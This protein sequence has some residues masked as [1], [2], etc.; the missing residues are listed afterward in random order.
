MLAGT[1]LTSNAQYQVQNGDF[2]T[3]T[4]DGVNLPNNW[5]SFQTADGTYASMGYSSSNRQVKK[6]ANKRPG[7]VG[8]SSC[9]IWARIPIGTIVAQGNV[10]T[11]RVHAGAMTAT[12]K[13]NYNYS[14][15]DG[16]NTKN[17]V[18]NP[19][20]MKFTGHPD[21]ISF[22]ARFVPAGNVAAYPNAHLAAIIHDDHDYITYGLPSYDND[23]NKGYVVANAEKDFPACDWTN[24]VVPFTYSNS[25]DNSKYVIVNI[26]TNAYPGKGTKGDSLYV[27]DIV[28]VYNSELESATYNGS[29]LTFD[30][31]GRATVSGY[32]E[33]SKLALKSNGRA[34][35]IEI[36]SYNASSGLL[37]VTVKGENISEDPNNKH[38]YT[39]KFSP[40][41]VTMNVTS[42]KWATFI[43]PFEITNIPTGVSAYTV[44]STTGHTLNLTNVGSIIQK[45]TPVILYSDATSRVF[46]YGIYEPSESLTYGLLTG[47]YEEITAP[48]GSYVLKNQN[49][50]V[51]FYKSIP[52]TEVPANRCYLNAEAGEVKAFFFTEDETDG[53]TEINADARD[54][55]IYDLHGR[56]VTKAEKGLYIING[57]KVLV[58]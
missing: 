54:N 28:M 35:T 10:T 31:T 43:A 8:S 4:F 2:E 37:T 49:G 44:S 47:T 51:G 34:A 36:D 12:G 9:C 1:V 53:I 26:S 40:C 42:A 19:C 14:D 11:G 6:S 18:T 57:K 27:D 33:P 55:A 13:E 30:N 20:A 22:W 15:R 24:F 46:R 56:R 32:Y 17:D 25:N 50:V 52:K 7:S 5:N 38:T 29:P 3:W 45:N 58:K 21:A 16:S 48:T 23:T 41:R 39:I